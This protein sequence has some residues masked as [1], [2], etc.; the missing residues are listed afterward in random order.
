MSIIKRDIKEKE[1]TL[2]HEA[3]GGRADVCVY[4]E[5]QVFSYWQ[6]EKSCKWLAIY[7]SEFDGKDVSYRRKVLRV[8]MVR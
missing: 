7:A 6:Q 1:W 5:G 4:D 3:K 2:G 8:R